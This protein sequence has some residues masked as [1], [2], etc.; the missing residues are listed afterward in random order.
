MMPVP[1]QWDFPLGPLWGSDVGFVLII[2]M[3]IAAIGFMGRSL[4]VAS[5]GAYLVFVW[6]ATNTGI[7]ILEQTA[8]ATL[9]LVAIGLAMKVWRL[10]GFESGS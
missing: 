3:I 8:Y 2:V 7:A 6:F 10:E 1:L 4:A 5:V 9:V